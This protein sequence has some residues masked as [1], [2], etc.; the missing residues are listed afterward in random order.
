MQIARCCCTT[1]CYTSLLDK[2]EEI[3]SLRA[4]FMRAGATLCAIA[5]AG[6]L[7]AQINTAKPTKPPVT[8]NAIQAENQKTG[9]SAW[10]IGLP[11]YVNSNDTDQWI[12]GY[13]S[14]VSINKGEKITFNITVNPYSW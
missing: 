14:A 4:L 7:R 12:R 9:T 3:M 5:F 13:G 2:R 10:Q 6:S 11:P 1:S 8:V